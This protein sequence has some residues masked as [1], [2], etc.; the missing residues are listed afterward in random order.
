MSVSSVNFTKNRF[1]G[2]AMTGEESV[3]DLLGANAVN[4]GSSIVKYSL[5]N[6]QIA[7]NT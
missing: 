5:D 2:T 1:K 6:C 4:T 3:G 7:V